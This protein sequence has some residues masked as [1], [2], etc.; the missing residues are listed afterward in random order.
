[1]I[2]VALVFALVAYNNLLNLWPPFDGSLYVPLNLAVTALLFGLAT[3]VMGLDA[4]ALGV[5]GHSGIGA[6][7]TAAL[8][9]TIPL[10]LA[11]R[12]PRA[13]RFIADKRVEDLMGTGL[14][15]QLVVRIPVGTALLEE[16]AFRGVLFGALMDFGMAAAAIISSAAFGLWHLV[17]TRNLV[18]ANRPDACFRTTAGAIAGAVSFTFLGGLL[19]VWMRVRTGSVAGPFVFHAVL[20]SLATLAAVLAHRTLRRQGAGA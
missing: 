8:V 6:G 20:N 4:T 7:V 13:A 5:A 12:L 3:T 15:Y 17:P 16:V 1:V 10:L 2:V 14:L 19:L 11:S 9:L 18:R